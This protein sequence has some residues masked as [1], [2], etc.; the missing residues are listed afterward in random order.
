MTVS[1]NFDSSQLFLFSNIPVDVVAEILA[2]VPPRS[3]IALRLVSKAFALCILE[4]FGRFIP[5]TQRHYKKSK[6]PTEWEEIVF[7]LPEPFQSAACKFVFENVSQLLW[8]VP[9]RYFDENAVP[10]QFPAIPASLGLI[11]SLTV[12]QLNHCGMTGTIPLTLYDLL[13][14]RVLDLESNKL[15]GTLNARVGKMTNLEWLLISD[16][17][18]SGYIPKEIGYCVSLQTFKARS[19]YLSGTI[20]AEIGQC[21]NLVRFSISGNKI[22]G[23]FPPQIFSCS[24]LEYFSATDN[25]FSG[26]IPLE[27]RNCNALVTFHISRNKHKLHL[28]PE[29]RELRI[30]RNAE[31]CCIHV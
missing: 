19:N 15:T 21:V 5:Q 2:W 25:E 29:L 14:L 10:C 20:P 12:L 31:S 6:D 26:S 4:N 22:G 24:K 7:M 27:I 30:F 8:R 1:D 13:Q 23:R 16:N 18:I 28:P 11:Q 17:K 9:S 3:L